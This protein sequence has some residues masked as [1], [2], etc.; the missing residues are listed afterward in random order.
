[1]LWF[2]AKE[3]EERL[4]RRQI[5]REKLEEKRKQKAEKTKS[6][7][8]K[9]PG[10]GDVNFNIINYLTY[11]FSSQKCIV[12]MRYDYK[13]KLSTLYLSEAVIFSVVEG[14]FIF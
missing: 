3:K 6:S 14:F 9:S 4:L 10:I 8:A 7:K 2:Q 1:M 13:I 5:N 12:L 11:S